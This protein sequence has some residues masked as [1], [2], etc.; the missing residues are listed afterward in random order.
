MSGGGDRIPKSSRGSKAKFESDV[1][2]NH[3]VL[4]LCTSSVVEELPDHDVET[5]RLRHDARR[6]K[7]L[8]AELQDDM[9]NLSPR[10]QTIS[11]R[12]HSRRRRGGEKG[13]KQKGNRWN[14]FFVF[15]LDVVEGKVQGSGY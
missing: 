3:Q 6:V 15:L 5:L 12:E 8:F 14:S 9:P 7:L 2:P 13:S 10:P 4:G 1:P 11:L